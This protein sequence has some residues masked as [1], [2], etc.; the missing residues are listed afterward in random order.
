MSKKQYW[1]GLEELNASPQF[2]ETVQNEFR[3]ELPFE[4]LSNLASAN[5]NRR[6]FLKYLGFTTAAATLAASC[7]MPVRKA[8]PYAIKPENVTPGVPLTFASTYVDAGEAVPVLVRTREGRPIKIEGNT[9]SSLTRG[10]TTARIQGSVLNLYDATRLKYPMLD[11]KEAR[12]ESIDRS[13]TEAM[14][15]MNGAAV[16]LVSS[17]V[18]SPSLL[19]AINQFQVKYP[20]VKHVMYDA[21]SYSGLLDANQSSFGSRA[22]PT[23]RFDQAKV[24]VS[25][26]A[27]FLGT[28]ISPEIYSKQYASGRKI[29]AKNLNMS[30]HYQIE[31]MMSLTGGSADERF[32]CKPSQ[33]GAVALAL[34]NALNGSA[35]NLTPSLNNAIKKIA[36]DLNANKGASLV[37]CGSNDP[38]VQ[39]LVNAINNAIGALGTTV[40]FAST[41]NTKKGSDTDMNAFAMALQGGQVGGVLFLDCN[42]V[43]DTVHGKLIESKLGSLKLSVSF[44]DRM[45]E[46]TSKCK[47][48]AP[49][50]HWLE[51]WGDAEPFTG[52]YSFQQP[53]IA[54]LFKTRGADESFLKWSGA[55]ITQHDHVFNAWST[56][57][58]GATAFDKA[59]QLGVMEPEAM[60]M[61]GAGFSGNVADASSKLPKNTSGMELM[62][63][64]KIGIGRGGV[65]SNNPWLQEMPDPL[66]K[67]T[68]DN[69]VILSPNTARSLGAE[70]TDLNEVDPQKFMFTVK[71]AG[72]EAK[73][74]VLVLPGMHDE[75]V[76]VAVGYGRSEGVGK[77]AKG[78]GVNVYPYLTKDANGN[79]GFSSSVT[80][81]KLTEKYPLA[82]TQTH[83]NY[84]TDRPIIHEFTY[85]EF[86]KNPAALYEERKHH[87]SH[88][89][90][91]F[92]D[93]GHEAGHGGHQEQTKTEKDWQEAYRVNGTLYP[94][95][96]SLGMKWGMSIDVNACTGCGAC[97]IACQA[98]NN[99]SVVGKEQVLIVHD[100][101]WIRI[102]RYFSGDPKNPDSIQTLF[103]PMLC[104]HCDNAPCE[105]VCP[106]NA[107][108]H[109][110]EGINQ[111]AYNRCIGTRYCANNCPYKVRRFNWRDWNEADCFADNVYED[112]RRDDMNNEIT[113]MV[114]NPDVTVRSRGVMEKCSFCVQR[115]QTAKAGAKKESRLMKD[116]EAKTACQTAC[117]TDAIVFG[118]VNDTESAIYKLRYEEQKERVFHV[119]EDIH[120]LPNI[121]YLSKI[122]NADVA[123]SQPAEHG[124]GAAHAEASH[125]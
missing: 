73:L 82:I 70:H 60:P 88:F 121:N 2:Q 38:S 17:T 68:W 120:T 52:Y 48:A 84:Q 35:A 19:N 90:H 36:A 41:N 55:N 80:I 29:S 1:K 99:V 45:D 114:L 81:T 57:L 108:N 86:K 15:A 95:H 26:G 106:V 94:N 24:I 46:T 62:V 110:S 58:G 91:S 97:T 21:M 122:R 39:T 4:D 5:T 98:E 9:D 93:G 105:N 8:I 66:T 54:P 18:N 71:T 69:Y 117:P 27:D 56:K 125:S 112:G 92:E 32:T 96:E 67:C 123:A 28:W 78:T 118:N 34:L 40:S 77:A 13:V 25:L 79:V 51:S 89:T 33:Y 47:I 44:N 65:W 83:Y 104:Q 49:A 113:R 23:Y 61:A 16:Y 14:A 72:H 6:D 20:N 87:L 107:T 119:L 7:E 30:K 101:H 12:W 43:Y 75:V 53:T 74:P 85:D 31:A 37:V 64:E 102:D 103:Q 42:P 124:H 11:G 115:L 50:H 109:S 63:Y 59:F 76:A 22:I 116:G 111:M 3:E 100:M 10:A